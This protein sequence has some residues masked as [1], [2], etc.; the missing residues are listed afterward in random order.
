MYRKRRSDGTEH[1][2]F[3]GQL[4]CFRM[5]GM[6]SECGCLQDVKVVTTALPISGKST[7]RGWAMDPLRMILSMAIKHVSDDSVDTRVDERGREE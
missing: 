5:R 6:R 3:I 2:L 7:N 1:L 4:D